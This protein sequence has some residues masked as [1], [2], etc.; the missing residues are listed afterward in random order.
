[1]PQFSLYGTTDVSDMEEKGIDFTR[2]WVERRLEHFCTC[3]AKVFTESDDADFWRQLF[4]ATLA[5]PRTTGY[6]LFYVYES[7]IIYGK[8]VGS[9]AI[10]DASQR[11]YDEKILPYFS[12]NRFLHE[13]FDEKASVLSLKELLE[14]LIRRQRD[15]K[16]HRD[17]A[18]MRDLP[19]VPP[20]SHFHIAIPFE[21][22]LSTLELNFF[23][24]K[25]YEMSDRDGRKVG[26]Y[27]EACR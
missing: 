16:K 9:K 23:I 8:R 5:N 4:Y 15:L 19:G 24:T 6:I 13:S 17:S 22:L 11:Y 20:T 18:V 12:M 10:R 27:N 14:I 3:S 1:M 7:H 26:V 25:Y 2:R 21:S